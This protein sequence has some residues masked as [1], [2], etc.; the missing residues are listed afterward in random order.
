MKSEGKEM[1]ASNDFVIT[2][3]RAIP[4]REKLDTFLLALRNNNSC[5]IREKK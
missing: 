2:V 3:Q 4:C 1:Q 5:P